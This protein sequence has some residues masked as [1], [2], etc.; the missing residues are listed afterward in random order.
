M[1]D[2][3]EPTDAEY[4]AAKRAVARIAKKVRELSG[5]LTVRGHLV[6]A[7]VTEGKACFYLS[8]NYDYQGVAE[9]ARKAGVD[10][11]HAL[12]SLNVDGEIDVKYPAAPAAE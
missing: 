6:N 2:Y 11:V 9:A 5:N 12:P 10:K 3:R 8:S 4:N 1:S 7:Y